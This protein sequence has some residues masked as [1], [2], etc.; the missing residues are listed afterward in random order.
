MK[1]FKGLLALVIVGVVAGFVMSLIA[2]AMQTNPFDFGD[3]DL[4]DGTEDLF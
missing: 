2:P 4:D 1:L 3:D